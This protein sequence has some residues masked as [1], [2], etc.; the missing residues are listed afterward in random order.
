[1][2]RRWTENEQDSLDDILSSG[3]TLSTTSHKVIAT[4]RVRL[5]IRNSFPIHREFIADCFNERS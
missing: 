4:Q 3:G 1:M 5:F 2:I